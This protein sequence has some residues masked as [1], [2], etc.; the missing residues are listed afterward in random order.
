MIPNPYT[1]M[2]L[3]YH[4]KHFYGRERELIGI[5]Q[6]LTAPY[7]SGHAIHGIRTIGKTTLLKFL[8]DKN[9]A[10]KRYEQYINAE[11]R[12]G[13]TR[14]L[15]FIYLNFHTFGED[16]NLFYL[17][18]D[19]LHHEFADL[20]QH[21]SPRF[22]QYEVTTPRQEL[23]N[24]LKRVLQQLDNQAIRVVFL[25]DDFDTPLDQ[26]DN[27]DDGLLRVISDHAVIIIATEAPIAELRPD[28]G[29]SSPFLGILRPETLGLLSDQAARDLINQ[30]LREMSLSYT[31]SE[32]EF[33]IEVGGKQPFVLTTACEHYYEMSSDY[34]DLKHWLDDAKERG[35]FS[36]Q[37][38]FRL[39]SQPH[40]HRIFQLQWNKLSDP[41][42]HVLMEIARESPKELNREQS[43]IAA[44]LVSK[45]LIQWDL[46]HGV[47][48]IFS[49]LFTLFIERQDQQQS[50]SH[51]AVIAVSSENLTP[52][53][54]A[55]L[56]YFQQ[57]EGRVCTFE[58]LL[59]AVW[60]DNDKSKR[61]LE[62]AVHR[63]RKTLR[64]DEAI[65]NIRGKG[66]KFVAHP[67][68]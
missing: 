44:R 63:I 48:G 30:P 14:Q 38:L 25:M 36:E 34:A 41:E 57:H 55:L 64:P 28:F 3:T 33:L 60:E 16:D 7:T 5:L 53:D 45:A 62:A 68:T 40:L 24:Q 4:P 26:L 56:R 17:L 23:V 22:G 11:Y 65:K 12:P 10:L 61:A 49:A 51:I 32:T 27:H 50:A 2:L 58:E 39:M 54:G 46:K 67:E 43:V 29:Q 35:H 47:Y 1:P 6:V 9:G 52:I 42:R 21:T 37:F 19:H 8:K 20:A 31:A 13:G 18:L 15:L 66:Y 59:D